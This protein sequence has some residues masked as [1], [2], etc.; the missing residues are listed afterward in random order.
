LAHGNGAIMAFHLDQH[1][2]LPAQHGLSVNGLQ[3][4]P[5]TPTALSVLPVIWLTFCTCNIFWP[6]PT[7]MLQG[8]CRIEF[9]MTSQAFSVLTSLVDKLYKAMLDGDAIPCQFV[10][11]A[12]FCNKVEEFSSCLKAY[13]D[14]K[15]YAGDISTVVGTQYKEQKMYH[16]TL[17]LNDTPGRCILLTMAFLMPLHPQWDVTQL[18][19]RYLLCQSR[20]RAHWMPSRCLPPN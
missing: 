16:A 11:F 8:R 2:C 10:V 19:H 5:A 7:H 1:Y 13:L 20:K 9:V 12:N 18:S 14:L 3:R 4:L 17:F 15:G 6:G